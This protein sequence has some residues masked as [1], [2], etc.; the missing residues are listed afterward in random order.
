MK[1]SSLLLLVFAL[2]FL[3]CKKEAPV[4]EPLLEEVPDGLKASL[5]IDGHEFKSLDSWTGGN[6]NCNTLHVTL[7]FPSEEGKIRVI[8][9]LS[10]NGQVNRVAINKPIDSSGDR[11][12]YFSDHFN[13]SR[14]F[15]ILDFDYNSQDQSLSFNYEG[16]IYKEFQEEDSLFIS[17]AVEL[18]SFVFVD[19][20]FVPSYLTIPFSP[21]PLNPFDTYSRIDHT[22]GKYLAF[23]IYNN[24]HYVNLWLDEDPYLLGLG[25]H[26]FT[27]SSSGDRVDMFH[28]T[29][30]IVARQVASIHAD[31]WEQYETSGEIIILDK[32]FHDNV[33]YIEG[34]LN[35]TAQ[36]PGQTAQN[37]SSMPF[38]LRSLE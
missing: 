17:G 12:Y 1:T 3:G 32:I 31:D 6:E 35:L 9:T 30:D 33:L 20:S 5:N 36:L 21:V 37:F 14:S 24:G 2:L 13:P 7:V 23:F 8:F 26:H 28:Y 25:S 15:Q 19:C 16:T 11:I 34:E 18:D 4:A 22:N 10:K 27:A 29:G 38:V